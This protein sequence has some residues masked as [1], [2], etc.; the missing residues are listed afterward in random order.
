MVT[1]EAEQRSRV[2]RAARS[3]VG[4]PYHPHGRKK[5]V[6]VDCLTLLAEV[7]TEA[8]LIESPKI[9]HYAPDF[10]KHKGT[11]LYLN[12]VLQYTRE[13]EVAKPGDIALWKYGRCFSHGAIVVDWPHIIHAHVGRSCML[14]SIDAAVWLKYI[15]ENTPGRGA[16]RPMKLLSFWDSNGRALKQRE[17][18]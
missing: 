7:Y 6:G 4:T 11:E 17:E 16:L 2:V 12:G 1:L 5:G 3:F 10:F 8:G 14:E 18:E 13:V 9:P 15:G